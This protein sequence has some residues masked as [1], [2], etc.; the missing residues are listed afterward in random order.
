MRRL[1][2]HV[3][4][5][6]SFVSLLLF[7]A[8]L[9]PRVN[10]AGSLSVGSGLVMVGDREV[11]LSTDDKGYKLTLRRYRVDRQGGWILTTIGDGFDARVNRLGFGTTR[12]KL[13]NPPTVLAEDWILRVTHAAVLVV[14]G[15]LP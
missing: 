13:L 9:T 12:V 7:T 15:L 4:T 14:S 2:R 11:A 1:A 10:N 6:C 3:F 8:A 5:L